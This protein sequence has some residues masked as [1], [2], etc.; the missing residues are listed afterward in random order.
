MKYKSAGTVEFLVD[1]NTG[2]FYFLEMN[3]RLQVEHGVTELCF[4]VGLVETMLVQAD[5]ELQGLDGMSKDTLFTKYGHAGGTPQGHSIE[6]WL[7]AENPARD[8][9]PEPGLLQQVQFPDLHGLRIDTWVETGTTISPSFDPLL[10]KIIIHAADRQ[11]AITALVSALRQTQMCGPPT[12]LDFLA[13]VLES[14][15]FRAGNTTTNMLTAHFDY[16]PSALEFVE[17]GAYTS[18]QDYPGRV[19]IPNGVP[20]SGPMDPLSFR[21]ANLL[22]G[23]PDGMEGFEITMTGPTIKFF[24]PAVVALCGADFSFTVIG[25][26][27]ARWTRHVLPP[28]ATIAV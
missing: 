10:A 13:Q 8:Y 5:A 2:D 16:V 23:N 17:A 7:Y 11:Q 12:N 14:E 20:P 27:A 24:G 6:A 21:V 18:I 19:G 25:K 3:T 28:D 9:R 15:H 22:V 26:P 1:E 4:G